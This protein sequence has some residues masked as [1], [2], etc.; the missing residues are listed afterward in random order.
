[1][2]QSAR[3]TLQDPVSILARGL[4]IIMKQ[5]NGADLIYA[6]EIKPHAFI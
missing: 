2:R 1:M 4:E 5:L 6:M 3:S